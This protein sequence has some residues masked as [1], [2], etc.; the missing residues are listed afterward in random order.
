MMPY[1]SMRVSAEIVAVLDR[2]AKAEDRTRQ[3]LAWHLIMDGLRARGE[4]PPAQE[5]QQG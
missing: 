4:W 1:I 3:G 2:V 5:V